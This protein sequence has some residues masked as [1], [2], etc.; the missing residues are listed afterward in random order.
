MRR[1]AWKGFRSDSAPRRSSPFWAALLVVFCLLVYAGLRWI[2]QRPPRP[3]L[4][5][6]VQVTAEIVPVIL[7]GWE[8]LDLNRANVEELM[9]LPGIGPVLAER[10]V[11]HREEH[12]PFDAPECLLDVEGVGPATLERLEG[13]VR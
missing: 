1:G 5:E 6:P 9:T 4:S 11:A 7:R 8:P 10:I 12:G 3:V 13:L 2:P